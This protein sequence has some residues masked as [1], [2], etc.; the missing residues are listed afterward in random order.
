LTHSTFWV[1]APIDLAKIGLTNLENIWYPAT[2]K[3]LEALDVP[4]GLPIVD[5]AMIKGWEDLYK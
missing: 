5:C 1:P 2:A 3:E 4:M